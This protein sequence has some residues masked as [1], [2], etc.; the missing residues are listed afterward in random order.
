MAENNYKLTE[1][2]N[3]NIARKSKT[4]FLYSTFFLNKEK[5]NALKAVYSFCRLSDDIVDNTDVSI[6]ERVKN[7]N[8]W[9]EKFN[10]ALKGN[11]EDD[12]LIYLMKLIRKYKIDEQYFLYILDGMEM[13]LNKNRYRNFDE[14]KKYC[15]CVASAVG[16]IFIRIA[17]FKSEKTNDYA[18][19]LGIA[20]QLTNILRDIKKDALNG[21]IYLPADELIKFNYSENEIL[22]NVYNDKFIELMKYQTALAKSYYLTAREKLDKAD[23]RPMLPARIIDRTYF[24]ILTDIE[25]KNFDIYNRNIRISKLK[26][27]FIPFRELIR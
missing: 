22:N 25:R 6:D 10:S 1:K 26:K 14:L 18:I 23:Y 3:L 15:F 2:E 17:G 27:I 9:R 4:N 13:D 20:L 5:S 8:T 21:R 7:L 12:S 16:L 19:N 24:N 11:S